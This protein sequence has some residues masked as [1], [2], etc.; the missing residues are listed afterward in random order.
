MRL[1]V[2]ICSRNRCA[3][4]EQTIRQVA[5]QAV[6]GCTVE[7]IV[8]DNGSS[9]GTG[10]ML[11]RLGIELG[12]RSV[13]E[14]RAGMNFARLGALAEASGEFIVFTDDDVVPA[15]DWLA[16]IVAGAARWPDASVFGGSIVLLYPDGT[17]DWVRTLQHVGFPSKPEQRPE[18]PMPDALPTGPNFAVRRALLDS[19]TFNTDIGPDGTATYVMGAETEFLRRA[20]DAGHVPIFIPAARVGHI[21]QPHQLTDEYLV[22]RAYRLGRGSVTVEGEADLP[23]RK[24]LGVPFY[25]WRWLVEACGMTLVG[26]IGRRRVTRLQAAVTASYCRGF[27]REVWR[28]RHPPPALAPAAAGSAG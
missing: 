3:L 14:R 19:I 11:R 9:D 20:R 17:P 13:Y 1:S 24:W 8:G 6:P 4:L 10:A 12:V 7:I 16:S 25:I 15:P 23:G 22:A 26:A 18:G 28:R 2:I 21:I 27:I 5:A